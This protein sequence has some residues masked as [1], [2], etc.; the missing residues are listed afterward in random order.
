MMIPRRSS[1]FASA[2]DDLQASAKSLAEIAV[3]LNGVASAL[4]TED[5]TL[6]RLQAVGVSTEATRA[7]LA[8]ATARGVAD[9]LATI[10]RIDADQEATDD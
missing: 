3:E 9:R 10:A 2:I 1:H 7:L 5:S 6:L 8:A 4:E